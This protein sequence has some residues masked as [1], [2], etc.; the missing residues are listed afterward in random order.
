MRVA[1]WCARNS[2]P[3]A[4]GTAKFHEWATKFVSLALVRGVA[5]IMPYVDILFDAM[6]EMK[7]DGEA[8]WHTW[9][10][11]GYT[12]GCVVAV[13]MT[14]YLPS[15]PL[16]CIGYV[17]AGWHR[18]RAFA[19]YD[20]HL[21]SRM[22]AC[23]HTHTTAEAYDIHE[24]MVTARDTGSFLGLEII[25]VAIQMRGDAFGDCMLQTRSMLGAPR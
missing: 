9:L 25:A 18:S 19:P 11:H 6:Q 12:I 8:R 16:C 17:V 13:T 7:A 21:R 22:A 10:K 20:E 5:E 2:C 1:S 15:L 14:G 23:S 24:R 3:F 4:P